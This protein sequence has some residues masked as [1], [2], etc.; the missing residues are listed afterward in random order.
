MKTWHIFLV[1]MLVTIAGF[2]LTA[3]ERF[4]AGTTA[5][6]VIAAVALGFWLRPRTETF[7][8]RTVVPVRKSDKV[9]VERGQVAV[10]VELARLWLLFIPTF[11]AVAFLVATAAQGSTWNFSLF[12]WFGSDRFGGGNP[13]GLYVLRVF[14]FF[15]VG[16]LSAWLGERWILRDAEMR[17]LRSLAIRGKRVSYAFVDSKG[18]YYGG[19]GLLVQKQ[20]PREVVSLAVYR[21]Q[22]PQQNRI[23]F[24]CLFHRFTI[25]GRG[26]TDLNEVTTAQRSTDMVPQQSPS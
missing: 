22:N 9:V 10:R 16:I 8:V 13:V 1:G 14:L 12:D 7:S 4:I 25:V 6:A 17:N 5:V 21:I 11:I 15:V 24:T 18:G 26:L 23:P 19:E 2:L 3:Y 20:L